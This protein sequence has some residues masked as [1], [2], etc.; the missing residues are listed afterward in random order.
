MAAHVPPKPS[1]TPAILA[2]LIIILFGYLIFSDLKST[3]TEHTINPPIEII[4][5]QE[6]LP[7]TV[8]KEKSGPTSQD[9]RIQQEAKQFVQNLSPA[10]SQPVTIKEHENQFVR[11]DSLIHIPELQQRT[12]TP[13]ALLNDKTLSDSQALTLDFTT[14]QDTPTTLAQLIK[15]I[16][17]QTIPITIVT[18]DGQHI[19]APLADII[20]QGKIALDAP[21]I[22]KTRH[23][24]HLKT[25]LKKLKTLNIAPE[26]PVRATLEQGKQTLKLSTLIPQAQAKSDSLFYLHRVTEQD[27]QGL[28]GIIQS[29]LIDKFRQGL[30][31]KGIHQNKEIVKAVIPADADEKLPSGMSSF[32]GKILQNKVK[33]SYIYNFYTKKMG[34]DPNLI[35]PGQQLILIEFSPEEL[36]E[37]YRYFSDKRHQDVNTY[38]VPD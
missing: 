29:G 37:I 9:Q 35:H 18:Q 26:Q 4:D 23:T 5:Q 6:T 1:L 28:W 20:Q 7:L 27:K 21:I 17:D 12:T 3:R 22:L 36:I 24:H 38:A 19:T 25:T 8:I 33:T 11:T 16:D 31:I 32:L 30:P 10:P 2:L 15:T 13:Q 34:R 14:Q